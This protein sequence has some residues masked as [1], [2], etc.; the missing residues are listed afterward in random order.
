MSFNALPNELIY[1]I[2]QKVQP[3]DLENYGCTSHRVRNIAAPFVQEH[4]Q[5]RQEY[6]KISLNHVNAAKLFYEMC[7]RPWVALYPRQLEIK[8]NR[9]W[10]TFENSRSRAPAA[11]MEE[12]RLKRSRIEEEDIWTL[13]QRTGLIPALEMD[14]WA[15]EIDRG[16]EDYL[17]AAMLA[18]LPNLERLIVR[19]DHIRLE[20]V[21]EVVR[22]IKRQT[23][24]P[25]RPKTLSKLF[26]ARVIEREG[27]NS[28]DLELFP[29]LASLP[30]IRFLHGRNLVG[31]Y[32]ECY[33]DGWMSYPGASPT[34]TH[35]SLETC[36][37]SV[38]GLEKLC[39]S[40]KTLRSFKYVAHRAGWGLHR[41]ADLLKNA[42]ETLEELVLSTG[43]GQSRFIGTLRGF[44]ALR[45]L[46]VDS[47]MLIQRG[48]MSRAVDILPASIETATLAGNSLT[49]PYEEQFLA[50]LYR[51]SFSYPN[52]RK[53]RVDDSWGVRDIG[54]D[55][56]KFQKEFHKQTSP[57]WMIRYR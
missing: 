54:K 14:T 47:G 28:C 26:D 2:S 31:L 45:N 27:A 22:A 15:R 50:D 41:I 56:L 44:T 29:L 23:S 52:L 13:L 18:C 4:R 21:K 10:R 38:E 25:Y 6:T 19:L 49:R 48:K 11:Q 17:F 35:I 5:L 9:E 40:I 34:I 53:L 36:G 46:T 32:R 39:D 20:Q 30:A 12:I 8:S 57:S 51:P 24:D 43:S 1:Q 37:M 55:R 3:A 16:N 7:A 33:R 42:R